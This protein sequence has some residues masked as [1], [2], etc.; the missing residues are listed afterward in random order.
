MFVLGGYVQKGTSATNVIGILTKNTVK[1]LVMYSS[2]EDFIFSFF[3]SS[4]QLLPS[5]LVHHFGLCLQTSLQQQ[6]PYRLHEGF[7][8]MHVPIW[9]L[10]DIASWL[11]V[12]S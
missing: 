8:T 2:Q 1:F 9:G 11:L 6:K 12:H 5:F 3:W 10:S 7:A 4:S